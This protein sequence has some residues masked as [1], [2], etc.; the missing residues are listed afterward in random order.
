MTVR[1]VALW[2]LLVAKAIAGVG[3]GWDIRWHIVIGRDSFWIAPHVMT[4]AGVAA[5]AMLSFGVLLYETWSAPGTMRARE[6]SA[7]PL[8]RVAGLVGTRGYHLAW[9][10]IALTILA[11]PVDDLWHRLFGI[12]VT[13][14]S[15]PHLLGLAG[16]QL[17]S[18]GCLLI[19]REVWP[20]RSWARQITVGFAALLLL[21]GFQTGVDPSLRTAFIHG[22]VRFFT[23][24]L[25]GGLFFT[26]A[27]VFTARFA[28]SRLMPLVVV[29]G[30]VAMQLVV[31]VVG[32]VGL[33]VL[34]PQPAVA[35]AIAGDPGSPIAV[36]H[37]I[38]RRNGTTPGRGFTVRLF[39]VLPALLLVIADAR[40]RP[41]A[42]G[43]TFGISLYL[44]SGAMFL[45]SPAFAHVHPDVVD[46]VVAVIGTA[47]VTVIAAIAARVFADW[48]TGAARAPRQTATAAVLVPRG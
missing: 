39:P 38:A 46:A 41:I 9:W 19:A 44:V 5:A 7:V 20:Q 28:E 26:F 15:P 23:Y 48:V 6:A 8:L 43:L 12:D 16:A 11:A 18:L 25:L 32:D 36:A 13:L 14:W 29:L 2:G 17:N 42:A 10:G 3:V 27:L 1:R 45:R 21:A 34:Q 33:A 22:G 47:V 31:I 30:G 37:E 4:Y 24:A 35:E 40:R